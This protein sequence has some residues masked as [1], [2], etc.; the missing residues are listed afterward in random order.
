MGMR[1]KNGIYVRDIFPQGLLPQI[2]GRIQQEAG[3]SGLHIN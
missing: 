2:R 3:A 1:I